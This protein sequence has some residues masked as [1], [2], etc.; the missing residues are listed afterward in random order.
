M[1]LTTLF[2]Q[3]R[4]CFWGVGREPWVT[5]RT[6]VKRS[7][8]RRPAPAR[9]R[10]VCGW[11]SCGRV[12]AGEAAL[13]AVFGGNCSGPV[14][15][16]VGG[17]SSRRCATRDRRCQ[18]A[19]VPPLLRSAHLPTRT[20]GGRPLPL[21]VTSSEVNA[22]ASAVRRAAGSEPGDG[23]VLAATGFLARLA[24]VRTLQGRDT[25]TRGRRWLYRDRITHPAHFHRTAPRLRLAGTLS[26]LTVPLL[27]RS[28]ALD[29]HDPRVARGADNPPD[30][31]P[32][33]LRESRLRQAG[34]QRTPQPP[35]QPSRRPSRG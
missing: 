31:R 10:A 2:P 5:V 12:V 26:A 18:V 16:G 20:D 29:A 24:L 21:D 33:P 27:A 1:P 7:Q 8:P 30:L 32:G 6:G 34:H 3:V 25:P 22:A 9:A 19:R 23:S 14:L 17:R 35:Q 13:A 28:R 11:P 15:A 4:A